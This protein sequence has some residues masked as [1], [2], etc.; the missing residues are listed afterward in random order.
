MSLE[1]TTTPYFLFPVMSKNI[2]VDTGT[3]EVEGTLHYLVYGSDVF[4]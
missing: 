3:C 2:M 4:Y 1:A